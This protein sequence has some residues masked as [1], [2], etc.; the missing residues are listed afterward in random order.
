M[1]KLI[2]ITLFY[3]LIRIIDL[4][5]TYSLTDFSGEKRV[6]RDFIP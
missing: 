1:N 5:V 6:P 2:N 4:P 3:V